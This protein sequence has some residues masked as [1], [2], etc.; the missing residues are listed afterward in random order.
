MSYLRN[1]RHAML[2]MLT[3]DTKC[4][5]KEVGKKLGM[6]YI[7]TDLLPDEKV[8]SLG[9]LLVI[10]DDMERVV[11]VG[12]GINDAPVLV[13]ADVGI[14]MGALGSDAALD[15]ADIILMDDEIYRIKDAIKIARET[16]R[17]VNMNFKFSLFVKAVILILTLFGLVTMWGAVFVD[18]G[19]MILAILNATWVYK[20]PV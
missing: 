19:V 20:Y 18:I 14:A 10:Q 1:R 11:F 13:E 5:G 17:V 4:S 9:D 12:D 6:D 15:A 16:L 7:Y 2:V 8:E 3:G